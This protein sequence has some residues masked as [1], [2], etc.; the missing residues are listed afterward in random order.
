M[1]AVIEKK[2]AVKM[3]EISLKLPQPF[4]FIIK[5][6]GYKFSDEEL[7]KIDAENEDF[8]I[9]T[10]ANGDLEIMP[11]P[12]PE[13]S[14]RN[15]DINMQLGNWAIK[16][17]NGVCFESSAKFTLPNGA[18]RM[19]DAAWILKERYFALSE[20]ERTERFTR[21]APDFVIELRSK[22][23]RLPIL[24]KKMK[25]YIENGVRLG[26][27]IDPYKKRVHVYRAD[28]KTEVFEN[29]KTV[30]GEDVLQGFELD[31][32]EIW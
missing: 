10:N 19:P 7:Y 23:D 2:Q 28:K 27:L 21:I 5:V 11:P 14:R 25:E 22:S 16:N 29:P 30:S 6:N 8:R 13:T 1:Q 31:L 4:F 17:E 12:F 32:T 24:Q 15:W 9:E 18:K 3:S 20:K 26:W